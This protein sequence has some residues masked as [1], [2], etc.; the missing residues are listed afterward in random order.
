MPPGRKAFIGV[1]GALA[2]L[3]AGASGVAGVQVANAFKGA[4]A[5]VSTTTDEST[6]LESTW[7]SESADEESAR[8]EPAEAEGNDEA[9][10]ARSTML[11]TRA[12]RPATASSR[13]ISPWSRKA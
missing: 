2:L 12:H 10:S 13:Q 5:S 3:V 7:P 9:E 11:R 4:P 8:D 1:V 6:E